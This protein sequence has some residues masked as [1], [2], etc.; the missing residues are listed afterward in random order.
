MTK[1]P[2]RDDVLR[3]MLKMPPA[4]FTPKAKDKPSPKSPKAHIQRTK[5]I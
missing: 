3:K 2:T 1:D 5:E 4:P